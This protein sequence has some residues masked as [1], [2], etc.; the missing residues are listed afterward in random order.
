M[1]PLKL[2]AQHDA[3]G[4]STGEFAGAEVV[5]RYQ[6]D[7][8]EEYR[9]VRATA[10][11]IERSDIGIAR[12][13]GRDPIRMLNGLITNDLTGSDGTAAVYGAMLTPKGR[14]ITDLCV[15]IQKV[16]EGVELV[17]EYPRNATE[18][19]REHL[20]K[21]IPPLFARWEL[22]ETI[23]TV[24]FYGPRSPEIVAALI[25]ATVP[26]DEDRVVE[27]SFH[28]ERV[29]G[30]VSRVAGGEMGLDLL[31]PDSILAEFWVEALHQGERVGARPLGMATLETLRI[32]AGRPRFGKEL[33]EESIPAEAY[34]TTGL[35]PRAISFT[36]GCY[37]GQEVVIRIAHRGHVN[38]HLRGLG[39]GE[40]PT[41]Q[42]GTTLIRGSDGKEVGRVTSATHSP[43]MGQT[44]A[45]G[46][47]RRE[48][49]PGDRV[50]IGGECGNEA[51][52]LELPF[53]P[54]A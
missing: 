43:L 21:Y 13:W 3:L 20:K 8:A 11:I 17:F 25:D 49:S 10:G 34:E 48:V 45:L 14:M 36:K 32:E 15:L 5:R 46:Y 42:E 47:L 33:T 9:A 7:P 53:E 6:G 12:M 44:I 40:A 4:A 41:P 27:G 16:G 23:T 38:R 2:H 28:D 31:I 24:G 37:T 22:V 52:V 29:V 19:L 18:P 26:L 39:L 50:R 54:V 51:T 30:V 35:L 1:H